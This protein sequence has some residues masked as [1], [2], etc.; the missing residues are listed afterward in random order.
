MRNINHFI[1]MAKIVFFDEPLF[2]PWL[3]TKVG[4]LFYLLFCEAVEDGVTTRLGRRRIGMAVLPVVLILM[5]FFYD[6]LLDLLEPWLVN[7]VIIMILVV[8]V[9]FPAFP[10]GF[11]LI[12]YGCM[13]A[14]LLVL[15]APLPALMFDGL[16]FWPVAWTNCLVEREEPTPFL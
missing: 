5:N 9:G 11:A 14:S 16:R 10:Y 12:F 7:D 4:F 15:L 13:R 2:W 3:A 1:F 8:S 6:P